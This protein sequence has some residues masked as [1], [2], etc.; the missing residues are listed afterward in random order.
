MRAIWQ[1]V[2]TLTIVVT[3]LVTMSPLGA[4]VR[5]IPSRGLAVLGSRGIPVRWELA[6]ATP[7]ASPTPCPVTQPNGNNPMEMGA[8]PGGYGNES[9]WTNL[10]M[11]GEGEVPAWATARHLQ[12][13]GSYADLKW[14]W[15]RYVPG[16]Q[17]IEGQRLDGPAPPLRADIPDGYGD[18][19]F[20]VSG[21][22][23]PTAGCWEITG[24]VGDASLTF[25]TLVRS[26]D[27]GPATPEATS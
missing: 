7:E 22:T 9:L 6:G 19:G 5:E 21:I 18:I 24:R 14:A 12:P 15:Y 11:W 1:T 2:V 8:D 3:P 10:W 25:V 23:F 20:Q 17:T 26:H 13:N 16:R 4:P 27:E